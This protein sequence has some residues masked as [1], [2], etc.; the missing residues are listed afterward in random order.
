MFLGVILGC[1]FYMLT[2]SKFFIKVNVNIITFLKNIIYKIIKILVLPFQFI[3]K[4]IKKI[5][6]KPITFI[7]INFRKIST[8]FTTKISSLFQ[9]NKISKNNIKNAK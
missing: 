3:Y 1:I 5:L 6:F 8:N 2:I 4:I 7:M 9:F